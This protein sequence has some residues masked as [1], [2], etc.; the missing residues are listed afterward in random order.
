MCVCNAVCIRVCV[1]VCVCALCYFC[2]CSQHLGLKSS[3]AMMHNDGSSSAKK[4]MQEKCANARALAKLKQ[5][6][7]AL[8]TIRASIEAKGTDEGEHSAKAAKGTDEEEARNSLQ[9]QEV[10]GKKET[11][12]PRTQVKGAP[13]GSIGLERRFKALW[14]FYMEKPDKYWK[15]PKKGKSISRSPVQRRHIDRG[16]RNQRSRS[17]VQRRRIDRGQRHQ[18]SRTPLQRMQK[19]PQTTSSKRNFVHLRKFDPKA[20]AAG[21][22]IIANKSKK[23]KPWLEL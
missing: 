14:A 2:C 22:K 19:K 3:I 15:K 13:A 20:K 4:L 16:K 18:R 12:T 10:E 11:A 8:Q 7:R 6:A 23:Q 5:C 1:S 17:H 21:R 9:H